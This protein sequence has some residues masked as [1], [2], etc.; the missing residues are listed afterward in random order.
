MRCAFEYKG[1]IVC[2]AVVLQWQQCFPE[3]INVK[4][5]KAPAELS[6]P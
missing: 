2:V 5:I 6:V 3:A 4:L 1:H